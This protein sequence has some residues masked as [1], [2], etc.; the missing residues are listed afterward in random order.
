MNVLNI[1]MYL[2]SCDASSSYFYMLW[3]FEYDSKMFGVAHQH[4]SA[5]MA[6]CTV[7]WWWYVHD[8][9]DVL[10]ECVEYHNCRQFPY[11]ACPNISWF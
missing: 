9:N 8:A 7:L 6:A 3:L 1:Y 11:L 5:A 4:A 10:C 2:L